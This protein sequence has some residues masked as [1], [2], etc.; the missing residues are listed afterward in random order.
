VSDQNHTDF[1]SCPTLV[2]LAAFLHG[3][4][5][6]A[7]R[8]TIERHLTK[9]NKCGTAVRDLGSKPSEAEKTA[10][11]S[12]TKQSVFLSPSA[13]ESPNSSA[14]LESRENP[15]ATASYPPYRI[16]IRLPCQLGQYRLVE[17][18]GAGGMGSVY[19]AEHLHLKKQVALK[20]LP[21]ER[22]A[23]GAAQARFQ[24]EMEVVGR[25]DHPNIVRATDAGV[26]ESIHYLVME[27]IDGMNLTQ[28]VR[29]H[30]PVPV[31]EACELI[32]QVALGLQH[33]HESGLVHRD[34]KPQNLMITS[35][36][37][38]KILDLGLAL[39]HAERFT[40]GGLTGSGQVMGTADYM[41]PEQ[42]ENC[43][44]VDIRAD[45][46]SL[47]CTLYFLLTGQPPFGSPD[48]ESIVRKMAA[49]LRDDP[50]A[51][52]PDVGTTSEILAHLLAKDP[53]Q[54]PQTPEEVVRELTPLAR[55][56]N[57]FRLF[58]L[59]SK[60]LKPADDA[61][62]SHAPDGSPPSTI[63]SLPATVSLNLP[64]GRG[65]RRA[66]A[67]ASTILLLAA[68]VLVAGLLWWDPREH[69]PSNGTTSAPNTA[70][71]EKT[72][73][74]STEN[75]G[76]V[77]LLKNEP[78]RTFWPEGGN[79]ILS[80]NKQLETLTIN[81][82]VTTLTGLGETNKR[83]Y[84]LQ[85]G[86]R[87]PKWQGGI[88][89]YIGG[90]MDKNDGNFHFQ[91]IQLEEPSAGQFLLSRS[92]GAIQPIPPPV[93]GNGVAPIGFASE[94]LQRQLTL[95][96]HILE[97]TVESFGGINRLNIRWAGDTYKELTT[98]ANNLKVNDDDYRG[99]F[100]II[101]RGASTTVTTARLLQSK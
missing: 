73:P 79:S 3:E 89:V 80:Y 58:D 75:N 59:A 57:L 20:L 23:D 84:K 5:P 21:P 51:F 45:L 46:Y 86:F 53:A 100:G 61:T 92:R 30:G 34:I 22:M 85:I 15:N 18:I 87:Q 83:D 54:R 88:G 56:A 19:R 43:H 13:F 52:K 44:W 82:F 74:Q 38:V 60:S 99:E 41:A 50:L 35:K 97:I 36:G 78:K 37:E 1:S 93:G 76:W 48:H 2:E 24:R 81:A 94:R 47:G 69:R 91:A 77:M 95:E 101:C 7:D 70:T 90:H 39:L 28:L 12:I 11:P 6:N 31:P 71:T 42:W 8:V 17:L 29:R 16:E 65:R 49:H 64:Q 62:W 40:P 67:V 14:V 98:P 63:S 9:C 33:A 25:L 55:G 26:V 32:R 66:W 72:D 96:E 10:Q 27:F 4:L 68:I